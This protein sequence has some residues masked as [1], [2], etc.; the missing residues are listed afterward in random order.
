MLFFSTVHAMEEEEL[1]V[2]KHV[3]YFERVLQV[4]HMIYIYS[5]P[6]ASSDIYIVY[7]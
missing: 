5:L 2:K 3:K 4:I 1:K 6:V 7:L